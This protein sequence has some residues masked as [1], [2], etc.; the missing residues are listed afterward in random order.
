MEIDL[1]KIRQWGGNVLLFVFIL[2]LMLDPTS[3]IFHIKDKV[4]IVV[5]AYNTIFFRP[6]FRFLPHIIL[7][8]VA[9]TCSFISGEMQGNGVDME[10]VLAEYK[11]FAPLILLLWVHHY[12]FIRVSLGP[13]LITALVVCLLYGIAS[14]DESFEGVIYAFMKTHDDTAMM[15]HRYLL[16]M[17]IF[18][19]YYKSFVALSFSL[20]YFYY[21]M[22]NDRK[23]WYLTIIPVVIFTFAFLVSGTRATMLL[24]FFV[25][26]LVGYGS[27]GKL[28]RWRYAFYPVLALFAVAFVVLVIAF[29]SETTEASNTI[30]YGHL[31]SFQQLFEHNPLYLLVGQGIGT[32]FYSQ[33][34]HSFT[35]KTEWTYLEL[36]RSYGLFALL[37][38]FTLLYPFSR[39]W[40]YRKYS[41]C[42]GL[43][44]T[45]VAYLLVAGTN[46]LLVSSTGMIVVLSIY[47]YIC[48]VEKYGATS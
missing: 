13:A 34:F 15:A 43:M 8:I 35:Y 28:G 26:A 30:K 3:T 17:K 37:I 33:G 7:V 12:D 46:P 1:H 38:L 21:K 42:F 4:F 25:A 41:F 2:V 24:P 16:G 18:A 6:S 5:V 32:H 44:G 14:Y 22:Y 47:S 39:L 11:A 27:I 31:V 10:Y 40:R 29:A 48:Y 9:I 23:H 19:I 45:Y 20:Y 36:L